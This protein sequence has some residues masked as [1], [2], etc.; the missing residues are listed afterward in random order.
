MDSIQA[1]RCII[2]PENTA[3]G[4]EALTEVVIN[5]SQDYG[6]FPHTCVLSMVVALYHLFLKD[7]P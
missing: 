3:C 4:F 6:R 2:R 5:E 1:I 7:Q